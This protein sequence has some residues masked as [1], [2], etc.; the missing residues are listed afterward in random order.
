MGRYQAYRGNSENKLFYII[1]NLIGGVNTEFSDDTSNDNEFKSILNFSIDKK[2]AL[3]KRKGFGRLNAISEIF[4]L[5]ENVPTIK[6]KSEDYPNPELENDNVVY[7]KLLLNDNNCFRSLSAFTGEKAY[8]EYQKLYGTQNNKWKLL[9]IT[10]N[11]N[12]GLSNSWILSCELPELNYDEHGEPTDEDTIVTSSTKSNLSVLFNWDRNLLNIETIEYYNK[13]YF[14]SNDKGLVCFDRSNDSFSYYGSSIGSTN[15]AY[16]PSPL[17]IRKVGFNVLGD[18]PLTWIDNQSISTDSIQGIYITTTNGIPLTYIPSGEAFRLNILYTGTDNG[19]EVTFKE[20]ETERSATVTANSTLSTSG[21]KVYDVMFSTQPTSNVE[22]KIKK[23]NSNIQDYYDYYDIKV[24]DKETKAVTNLNIGDYGIVEMFSRAVYYKADTI[25]FS[26][27]N[28]YNYIPNYNYV[29][30]PIEPTDKITKII[31]FR[32]A[33][34]IFTKQRIYKM[35]GSFGDA[36]FEIIPVNMSIGCHAPNTIVPI[37]NVLY[38]ASTRGLYELVN[39]AAYAPKDVSYEN[40]K[41][42]DTKIKS[43][44]SD[45]TLYVEDLSDPSIKYSGITERAYALRYKDKYMLFFNTFNEKG[46]MAGVKNIDALTYQYDLR[47]FCEIRFPV[48]PTFMFMV[49]NYIETLCTVPQREE[50]TDSETVI[51]FDFEEQTASGNKFTDLSGKGHDAD[52]VGSV[53]LNPGAGIKTSEE[54][55]L[56]LSDINNNIDI[57]NNGLDIDIDCNIESADGGTIFDIRQ[58]QQVAAAKVENFTIDTGWSNGYKGQLAITLTPNALNGT[59]KIDWVFNWSRDNTS[60][61]ASQNGS[62]KLVDKSNNAQLINTTFSFNFGSATTVSPKSGTFNITYDENRNYSKTWELTC[63]SQYPVSGSST[64]WDNGGAVSFDKTSYPNTS[65]NFFQK[66]Y[67]IRLYGTA[68]II[69]NSAC[70]VRVYPVVHLKKQA[71][72]YV[73][74]RAL[75]V[76]ING[77][78]YNFTI[79]SISNSGSSAYNK[80][81]SGTQYCEQIIYYD[82]D[83]GP[84]ISL[85]ARYHI[86]ATISGTHRENVD[87]PAFNITLPKSK[88]YTTYYTNWYSFSVNG[89]KL[90][91]PSRLVKPSYRYFKMTTIDENE[92][93]INIG[94]DNELMSTTLSFENNNLSVEGRHEW[95]YRMYIENN[96]LNVKLYQDNAIFGET[97]LDKNYLVNGNRDNN[98]IFTNLD[99]YIY[100]IDITSNNNLIMKYDFDEGTGSTLTNKYKNTKDAILSGTYTWQLNKG[101]KF[102]GSNGYLSIPFISKNISFT[103]GFYVEFENMS[104]DVLR[105]CKMFDFAIGFNTGDG[106][107]SKSSINGGTLKDVNTVVFSTTSLNK[108]SYKISKEGTD[109]S[110]RHKWKFNIVNNGVDY[111]TY[112]YLDGEIVAQNKNTFGGISNVD[113]YSNFIGKSNNINDELFKGMLY[114]FKVVINKSALPSV[115]YENA[116]FEYDTMYSD[117]GEAMDI[118]LETKG[119]NLQYPMH[120]KKLKNLF[121]KGLG[122]YSY[123]EFILEVYADGHLV[124]DPKKYICY[125]DNVTHQIVYDY[126]EENVLSFNEQQSILGNIRLDYT[127]LGNTEYETRKIIL[128]SSKC[129]NIEVKIY[130]KSDDALSIESLGFLFKLGKVK[131]G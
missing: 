111:D 72:L 21:L 4:N 124:N 7:A 106:E 131:Q 47:A 100:K 46:D 92:H 70:R 2:G 30:L 40:I 123:S 28:N 5:F 32:N 22:I 42:L 110:Q 23:T 114:N 82:Q 75:Y 99:G 44:T 19:F 31:Y 56:K 67:G 25:W 61:N 109:L 65:G 89:N 49:D 57:V 102:D 98:N 43:I 58:T 9:I 29:T 17:E 85:D 38:F 115:V 15:N 74:S 13:I 104:D 84:T 88:S 36:D 68:E 119:V 113:R 41:E 6:N 120:Q 91:N 26:E 101:L 52:I 128:P 45:V 39:S 105:A 69:G 34:I 103:N 59:A 80:A 125:V 8:R 83:P 10:T 126:T 93:K 97:T 37:E 90:I 86:D 76:W 122:G 94:I 63:S 64:S 78:Q 14:T 12:T 87:I 20:G 129:K 1:D 48:K 130:G 117:F 50:Y 55:N 16:K 71:S 27:I 54:F 112:I 96:L 121:V 107:T 81:P 35:V 127:R 108:K 51:E 11:K 60:R 24:I 62:F 95:L 66:S 53:K 118:E 77:T 18:T 73:S 79:P 3:H 116:M 33:Y